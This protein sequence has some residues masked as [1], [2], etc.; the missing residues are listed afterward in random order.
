MPPPAHTSRYRQNQQLV[1]RLADP[2]SITESAPG[3]S[4]VGV[5]ATKQ[6]SG[7]CRALLA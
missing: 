1:Q 6:F 2:L 3:V 7:W 5:Q 4:L